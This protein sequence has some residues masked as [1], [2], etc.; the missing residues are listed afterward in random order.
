MKRPQFSLDDLLHRLRYV[1]VALAVTIIG[2]ILFSLLTFAVSA[3]AEDLV[4]HLVN[5]TTYC[6]EFVEKE[7][8]ECFAVPEE[9]KEETS[10]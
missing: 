8:L 3:H 9:P 2:V 5:D 10:A 4:F 1:R 7:Y 6:V